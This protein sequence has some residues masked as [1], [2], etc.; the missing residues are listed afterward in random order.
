MF[1][2]GDKVRL[3]T[4]QKERLLERYTDKAGT[5]TYEYKA[6]P[7]QYCRVNFGRGMFDYEDVGSWRLE[8]VA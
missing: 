1:K 3:K 4:S 5:V 2:L 6:G 7:R 8:R